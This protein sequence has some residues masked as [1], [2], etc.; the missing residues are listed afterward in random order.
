MELNSQTSF[1]EDHPAKT[2]QWLEIVKDWMDTTAPYLENN[3]ESLMNSLP[4]GFCGK[5]SLTL[6]TAA[7]E[8]TS[9]KS[10]K[11]SPDST[12]NDQTEDGATPESV[13]ATSEQQYGVCLTLNTLESPSI[14]EESFLWQILEDPDQIQPQYYLSKKASEGILRRLAKTKITFPERLKKNLEN[15]QDLQV[16]TDYDKPYVCFDSK[17]SGAFPINN[18]GTVSITIKRG[19]DTSCCPPAIGIGTAIRKLTETECER[20]MGWPDGYT[21]HGLNDQGQP[22]TINKT[23]RYQICGNGIVTNITKWLGQRITNYDKIEK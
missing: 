18:D 21:L 6:C 1:L 20:L 15:I 14:V 23:R 5:T 16:Y 3:V 10:S 9:L 7:K 17:W 19:S 12:L 4:N 8:Q 13:L 22:I 2:S 11:K